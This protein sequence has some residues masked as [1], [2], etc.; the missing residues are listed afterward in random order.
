VPMDMSVIS[1]GDTDLAKYASPPITS[2]TWDLA[3]TGRTAAKLLLESLR[4]G[5]TIEPE[6]K[7]FLPTRLTIRQSCAA[8]RTMAANA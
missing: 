2:I 5:A 6:T 4:T 1:I 3:E 7:M 8:P